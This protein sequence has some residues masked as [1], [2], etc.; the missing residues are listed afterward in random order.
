[1]HEGHYAGIGS[2]LH[3]MGSVLAWAVA[4]D[5]IYLLSYSPYF[6]IYTEGD[7]CPE[8]SAI[9]GCFFQ[10]VSSCTLAD[11]GYEGD[12]TG[13]WDGRDGGESIV[14]RFRV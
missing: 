14:S 13:V 8:H 11:A 3:V 2:Q 12:V 1:V 7:F 10:P 9:D 6:T 5:R 4:L